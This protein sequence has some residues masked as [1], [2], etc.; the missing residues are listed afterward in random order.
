MIYLIKTAVFI[1]GTIP[2]EDKS[3]TALKIG[4]SNDERGEGRFDDYRANGFSIRV[5]KS[6]PGGSYILEGQ[7]HKYFKKYNISS[8]SREWFYYNEEI[9]DLFSRCSDISDLYKLFDAKG[10]QELINRK[11]DSKSDRYKFNAELRKSI[12]DFKELY[13]DT[14]ANIF[15]LLEQVLEINVFQKRLKLIC[16]SGLNNEDLNIFLSYLPEVVQDYYRILG[17]ERITAL[18]FRRCDLAAE[19]KKNFE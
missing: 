13:G 3:I 2:E 17:P 5:L 11:Y 18:S 4:Y 7:I 9:V 14:K 15:H 16:N 8:R 12:A 10:D 6:I 19:Y 1:E